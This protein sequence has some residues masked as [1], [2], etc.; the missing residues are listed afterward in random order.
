MADAYIIETAGQTAGIVVR[1]RH[2]VRFFASEPSFYALDG[3]TFDTIRAVHS[4]VGT[5]RSAGKSRPRNEQL[6]PAA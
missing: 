3:Q 5:L 1:E 6:K 4:A 2:G